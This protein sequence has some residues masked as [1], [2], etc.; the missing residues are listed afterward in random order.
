M[1]QVS[2]RVMKTQSKP[3]VFISHEVL[4]VRES[5][6]YFNPKSWSKKGCDTVISCSPSQEA[7]VAKDESPFFMFIYNLCKL[8]LP[9]RRFLDS[10]ALKNLY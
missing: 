9:T 4:C 5:E 2:H 6:A 1:I 7:S 3:D 10:R 8:W